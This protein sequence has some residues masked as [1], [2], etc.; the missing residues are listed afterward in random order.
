MHDIPPVPY[1]TDP[2][3][4]TI[5][6]TNV[7][8]QQQDGQLVD[9]V[10]RLCRPI[11]VKIPDPTDRE[12][13]KLVT[14]ASLMYNKLLRENSL[15][16]FPNIIGT[17]QNVET[18]YRVMDRLRMQFFQTLK[19][20]TGSMHAELEHRF[21]KALSKWSEDPKLCLFFDPRYQGNGSRYL[22][23]IL[24]ANDKVLLAVEE[25]VGGTRWPAAHDKAG[26][27]K[28]TL[29]VLIT[30]I[31]AQMDVVG[32]S[33]NMQHNAPSAEASNAA[34]KAMMDRV[35]NIIRVAN[36]VTASNDVP[37]FNEVRNELAGARGFLTQTANRS[38]QTINYLQ[39]VNRLLTDI[40]SRMRATSVE[41]YAGPP[42][43]GMP[44]LPRPSG[45]AAGVVGPP[46]PVGGQRPGP[47]QVRPAG[48]RPQGGPRPT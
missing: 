44:N 33:D 42:R 14:Q 11:A 38:Q 1:V 12:R 8:V 36:N 41:L 37:R 19:D 31:Q 45:P 6:H 15:V 7:N 29:R 26:D 13:F 43:P 3:W 9:I 4:M 27:I 17:Q 5:W 48:P 18:I 2:N 20:L 22:Y 10:R 24:K 21:S 47:P 16:Q 23:D 28:K 35:V 34:A 40:E 46:R 32:N 25:I 39:D 30:Y